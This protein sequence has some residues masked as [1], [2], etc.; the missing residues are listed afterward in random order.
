M[1]IKGF[2]MKGENDKDEGMSREQGD[3]MICELRWLSWGLVK[4]PLIVGALVGA[5]FLVMFISMKL[6]IRS[7]QKQAGEE[8]AKKQQAEE[9][10]IYEADE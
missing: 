6:S 5:F 1:S 4:V 8:G 7:E 9:A 2:M 10:Q 3:K